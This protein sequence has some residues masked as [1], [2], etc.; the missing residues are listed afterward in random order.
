MYYEGKAQTL[1]SYEK[2]K[3]IYFS[4]PLYQNTQIMITVIDCT[5]QSHKSDV[6]VECDVLIA[7]DLDKI[8]TQVS[9]ERICYYHIEIG[10]DI[11]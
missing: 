6:V 3:S 8:S 10:S 7:K 5:E 1:N 4:S 9:F 2:Q 11:S